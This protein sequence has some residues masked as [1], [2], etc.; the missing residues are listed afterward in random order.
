MVAENARLTGLAL[1]V[2]LTVVLGTFIRLGAE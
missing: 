2:L 1:A